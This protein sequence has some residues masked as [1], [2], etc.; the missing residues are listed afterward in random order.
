M[1]NRSEY[2]PISQSVDH[3][4]VDVSQPIPSSFAT[5]PRRSSISK[6]IDLRKLD[7]AFK[8]Y[9]SRVIFQ[10]RFQ[11]LAQM[12]RV[13]CA[14]GEEEEKDR[15][16]ERSQGNLEE[17]IRAVCPANSWRL[18]ICELFFSFE[19]SDLTGNST[20]TK[21]LDHRPPMSQAE[22]DVSV[23]SALIRSVTQRPQFDPRC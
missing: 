4:E 14:K 10:A 12:D 16:L 8:R 19:T 6:K 23:T 1:V 3:D 13:Y 17:R 18:G 9:V 7:N 15:G 2:Q 11:H 5:R 22:F 21:T 20:Q